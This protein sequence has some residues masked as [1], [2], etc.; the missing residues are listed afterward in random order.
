MDAISH[1]VAE[2]S[3][4]CEHLLSALGS[5]AQFSDLEQRLIGYYCHEI[6][7][8]ALPLLGTLTP[9]Q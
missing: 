8:K 6:M 5:H 4:G 1:D 3:R 2:F 9:G 7:Q